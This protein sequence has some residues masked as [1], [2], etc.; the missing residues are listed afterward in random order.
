MLFRITFFHIHGNFTKETDPFVN[1]LF[2]ILWKHL[3]EKK[4]SFVTV[5]V[6]SSMPFRFKRKQNLETT[7]HKTQI[8]VKPSKKT[9]LDFDVSKLTLLAWTM[10]VSRFQFKC[11]F[12][13]FQTNNCLYLSEHWK[14]LSF[15][16]PRYKCW[17]HLNIICLLE[18]SKIL[19]YSKWMLRSDYA[20][21]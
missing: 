18:M 13:G 11:Q 20:K 4:S 15:K 17:S 19:S 1:L 16:N 12:L 2:I 3:F 8:N 10:I 5:I 7:F 14:N 21:G 9:Y 6:I